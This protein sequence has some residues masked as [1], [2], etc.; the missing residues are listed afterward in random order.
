MARKDTDE[1][2]FRQLFVELVQN[3]SAH[4]IPNAG[5]AKTKFRTVVWS[6]IF[7][8]GVAGFL[9]QFSE[10]FIRFID[11]PVTTNVDVTSNRSLVFPAVTICNQNPVRVSALEYASDPKLRENFD[12]TYEP[13]TSSQAP[14]DV[15]GNT[16]FTSP[17]IASAPPI[18][19]PPPPQGR[20]RRATDY[21]ERQGNKQPPSP[22]SY[23]GPSAGLAQVSLL[24]ELMSKLSIEERIELGH[25]AQDF[26]VNCTWQGERC[27]SD[28]FTVFNNPVYG[29]CF[30]FNG[31]DVADGDV[32]L[33]NFPG[34]LFGLSLQLFIEQGEYLVDYT[35]IAGVRIVIHDRDKMPFPEDTGYTVPPGDSTSLGVRRV[36]ITRKPYP[37]SN[38]VKKYDSAYSNGY[39]ELY[40][41][42]YSVQ[43]CMKD[44]YQR[45]VIE[46]CQC[47]D[48]YYP[49]D[50]DQY[51]PCSSE[52][53][54]QI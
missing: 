48:P 30:T 8:I 17:D 15:T 20:K 19:N 1:R 9:F 29:N 41:V 13:S 35:E 51:Q 16:A 6:I 12:D 28:N 25:Q 31:K 43:A 7:V 34:P 54:D 45:H 26:I 50:A 52:D 27:S 10:L 14:Q 36:E 32:L 5:R 4:G 3:S 23:N 24:T 47:A 2:S 40:G 49:F 22:D 38:C 39:S 21:L 18:G 44:C 42:G 46:R 53:S 37:Y 11:F 33:T